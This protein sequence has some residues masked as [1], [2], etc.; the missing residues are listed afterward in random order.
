MDDMGGLGGDGF[1]GFDFDSNTAKPT[2]NKGKK[3]QTV[4]S[5]T[6]TIDDGMDDMGGREGNGFEGFDFDPDTKPLIGSS[7]SGVGRGGDGQATRQDRE[8]RGREGAGAPDGRGKSIRNGR[9]DAARKDEEGRG[10]EAIDD[11]DMVLYR[12]VCAGTE[13]ARLAN[14]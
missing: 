13:R 1:E 11:A 4:K 8:G 3:K 14:R 9:V 10:R 2:V 7:S 6:T 12:Y 5:T